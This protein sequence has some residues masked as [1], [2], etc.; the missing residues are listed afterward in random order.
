[1]GNFVLQT[2]PRSFLFLRKGPWGNLFILLLYFFSPLASLS[3]LF[4]TGGIYPFLAS[5]LS[6]LALSLSISLLFHRFWQLWASARA[7]EWSALGEQPQATRGAGTSAGWRSR[8]SGTARET[9]KLATARGWAVVAARRTGGSGRA[10]G[11]GSQT[12]GARVSGPAQR[13]AAR[14]SAGWA[15]AGAGAA[16][17]T[18][19]PGEY[20]HTAARGGQRHA[21]VSA[22][23]RVSLDGGRGRQAREWLRL[24]RLGRAQ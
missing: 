6:P 19:G 18:A 17:A 10:A 4:P 21:G 2:S 14:A 11:A 5:S 22:C 12:R 23:T 24:V 20:R 3:Y 1:M 13:Q 9:W 8:G 15:V 7:R 16:E